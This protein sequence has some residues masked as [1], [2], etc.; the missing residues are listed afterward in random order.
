MWTSQKKEK[1]SCCEETCL[2][3]ARNYANYTLKSGPLVFGN[4]VAISITVI[5]QVFYCKSL[6]KDNPHL[7][8]HHV[9]TEGLSQWAID[10][11]QEALTGE[12]LTL[13][14]SKSTHVELGRIS[15]SLSQSMLL[16]KGQKYCHY[17]PVIQYIKKNNHGS[18]S[19]PK[20]NKT[21]T[22][23]KPHDGYNEAKDFI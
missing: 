6:W 8:I 7:R 9:V 20:L 17:H 18:M 22:F 15:L 3:H 2:H 16:K 5:L 4:L 14:S 19:A 13:E 23:R 10:H 1:S 11:H 12:L 21:E